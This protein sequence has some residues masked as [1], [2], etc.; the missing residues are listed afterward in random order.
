MSSKKLVLAAAMLAILVLEIA[1]P[2][3]AQINTGNVQNAQR[4][5]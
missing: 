1:I 4:V 3:A 2:A 5:L